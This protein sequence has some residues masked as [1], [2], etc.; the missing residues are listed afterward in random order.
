MYKLDDTPCIYVFIPL[1]YL[2]MSFTC[3][4]L[5][6]LNFPPLLCLSVS[7]TAERRRV[8]RTDHLF[9]HLFSKGTHK[10]TRQVRIEVNKLELNAAM[11]IN[12]EVRVLKRA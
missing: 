9:I 1:D 12:G 8:G 7:S 5:R 3:I 4:S 6:R 10:H 11:H 2:A